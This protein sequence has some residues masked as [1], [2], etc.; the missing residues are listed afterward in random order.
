MPWWGYLYLLVLVLLGVAGTIEQFRTKQIVHALFT[1][2]SLCVFGVFL[3]AYFNPD[4]GRVLSYWTIV[5]ILAAGLYDLWLSNLDLQPNS[6][7]FL[8]SLPDAKSRLNDMAAIL[9]ILPAYLAGAMVC[10]RV[11]MNA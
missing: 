11:I 5:L 10:Y 1:L 3:W 4:F 6:D 7:N 8:K 9:I 2:F